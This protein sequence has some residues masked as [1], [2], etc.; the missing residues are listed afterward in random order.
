MIQNIIHQEK[1][2]LVQDIPCKGIPVVYEVA[3]TF[4]QQERTAPLSS[5]IWYMHPPCQKPIT[6]QTPWPSKV[7]RAQQ[8][9][10]AV[11]LR[12][13]CVPTSI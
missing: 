10:L 8:S 3:P 4:S 2:S 12:F 11:A 1:D 6:K 9:R 5:P 7:R 13:K